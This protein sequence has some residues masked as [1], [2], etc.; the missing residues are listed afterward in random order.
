MKSVNVKIYVLMAAFGLMLSFSEC[1]KSKDPGPSTVRF[2][3]SQ[4]TYNEDEGTAEIEVTLSGKQGKEVTIDFTW[5]GTATSYLNG[6]FSVASSSITIAPGQTIGHLVVDIID[7]AQIDEDDELTFTL[8]GTTS[9]AK[10]GSSA[11]VNFDLTIENN[12]VLP[13]NKLQADLTW[14]T[15]TGE[16]IDNVDLDLNLQQNVV[17]TGGVV[18]NPGT[19]YNAS[20]NNS[21]F[22]TL[23]VNSGDPD[24]E[25][26]FAIPYFQGTGAVDF[27]LTLNG[28]GWL[29]GQGQGSFASGDAGTG[30]FFIGPFV[31]N[32]NDFPEGRSVSPG[33]H[34]GK[35]L[36]IKSSDFVMHK[37][38]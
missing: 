11:D 1:N 32:G 35:L 26:W 17:L 7:D 4:D 28:F 2:T 10:L 12:D 33:A 13:S 30:L 14:D 6:D 16:D 36:T 8:S 19:T 25:Y 31:K 18:T 24:Q 38:K 27:T 9:N 29:N 34:P 3:L 23:L 15:G 21:G 20:Q 22:E 5:S 37:G